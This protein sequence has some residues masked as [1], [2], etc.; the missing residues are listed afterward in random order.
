MFN[1]C[2]FRVGYDILIFALV[3]V[4]NYSIPIMCNILE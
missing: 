1:F 2:M 3:W 4:L